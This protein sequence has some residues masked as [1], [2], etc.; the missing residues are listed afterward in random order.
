MVAGLAT[1]GMRPE[2]GAGC[3]ERSG[4]S[5]KP[6]DSSPAASTSGACHGEI[7]RSV[8][9]WITVTFA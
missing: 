8:A 2:D 1:I 9:S 7:Q 5:P 3:R 4:K 6:N